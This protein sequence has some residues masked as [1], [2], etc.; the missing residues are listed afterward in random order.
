MGAM[1][2]LKAYFGMVPADEMGEYVDGEYEPGYAHS[3][4]DERSTRDGADGWDERSDR[5]W[6]DDERASYDDEWD[7][8]PA[9]GGRSE[10]GGE[11]AGTTVRDHV[12]AAGAGA[13]SGGGGT[14]TRGALAIDGDS[15]RDREFS[16]HE[17]GSR[18]VGGRPVPVA[19]VPEQRDQPTPRAAAS[20]ARIVTLHPR[21]YTEARAIGE[22]FRD[23]IP[24]IMNLTELDAASAKRLVDFAAGLVFALR[25]GFEKVTNRVFL[26]TPANVEVS[27]D[28]ARMLATR[29]VSSSV[30]ATR[31][32]ADRVS[33]RQD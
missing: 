21:S 31:V 5:R 25:G 10:R 12:R 28:D 9:R 23:G 20:P 32:D 3:R 22:R 17:G 8:R 27:A 14:S 11:R 16:L 7:R 30:G 4:H 6:A 1:Y 13:G 18:E 33:F 15:P 19:A 29:S 26:L 24:V 2:R